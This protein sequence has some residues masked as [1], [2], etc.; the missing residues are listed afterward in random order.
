MRILTNFLP[1]L[2]RGGGR[3]NA[4]NLWRCVADHGGEHT[5]LAV[6]RVGLGIERTPGSPWQDLAV[7]SVAGLARRL[8]VEQ[9]ELPRLAARFGADVIFTPMGT[10]PARGR[11]PRVVGWHDSTAVYPESPMWRT[12]PRA[13][14]ARERMRAAYAKVVV[15]RSGRICVQTE[16][17]AERLERIWRIPRDRLRVIANGPSL[18]LGA[19]PQPCGPGS[20]PPRVLVV[21]TAQP[22]KNLEI[23]PRVA[24]E[25]RAR[26]RRDVEFVLTVPEG[27]GP[28]LDPLNRA[29][30]AHPG[31]SVH[32]IG[33]V[34]QERLG[35]L[36]RT[37]A[38]V[39]V[40]S[41][42]ESFT[43]VYPEA[44][45][46]GVP[47]VTSDLPFAREICG[48]AAVYAAHTDAGALADAV[49]CVLDEVRVREELRA[50]GRARL[51][52]L[53]TWPERF[54]AYVEVLEE[55]RGLG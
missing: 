30:A 23:V 39:L 29:M 49:S 26:G 44:W 14:V 21:A 5:W 16:A 46:Y 17:M 42:M 22:A 47:V 53:P 8:S 35:E 4:L 54:R 1:L 37:G 13:T 50:Q 24:A 15:S 33:P 40:P 9:V 27:A 7:R 41:H 32:R 25:L 2:G 34:T 20:G 28:W 31:G 11:A 38:C 12:M 18:H 19:D 55:A 6:C 51:A 48:R 45:H 52:S 10:G 43:A 3:Q 36:Y